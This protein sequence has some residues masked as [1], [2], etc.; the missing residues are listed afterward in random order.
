MI[1]QTYTRVFVDRDKLDATVAFHLALTGGREVARFEYPETGL[2]LAIVES[3]R[4]SVLVIAGTA[5]GRAPFEATKLTIKVDRLET[6]LETLIAN[7]AEQ[8]EPVVRTPV[9][10]KT[11]FRHPDGAI[12]EY[13]DHDADRSQA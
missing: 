13:V 7:G 4:L 9:G 5:E 10:R 8:L 1:L 3:P 11:R 12:V 2:A 6:I